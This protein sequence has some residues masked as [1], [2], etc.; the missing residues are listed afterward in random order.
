MRLLVVTATVDER[1]AVLSA[2]APARLARLLPYVETRVAESGAGTL[3]VLPAGPGV[4]AA[5]AAAAVGVNRLTPHA[6]LVAGVSD[7]PAF[8]A[9]DPLV[10]ERLAVQLADVDTRDELAGD[11]AHGAVV[12][13]AVH[14]VPVG[15]LG[16]PDLAA[17]K[18]LSTRALRGEWASLPAPRAPLG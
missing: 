14:G 9:G 13:A 1:D 10:L 15:Q 8:V 3:V 7:G 18:A 17:L 5:A 12:A 16:A 4:A 2:F 6:L 11:T